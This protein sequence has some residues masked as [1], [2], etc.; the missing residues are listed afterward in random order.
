MIEDSD[1]FAKAQCITQMSDLVTATLAM[2]A[3]LDPTMAYLAAHNNASEHNALK[4]HQQSAAAADDAE[5]EELTEIETAAGDE[6]EPSGRKSP[7]PTLR[8]AIT[9]YS[10]EIEKEQAL[11]RGD[12]GF[13]ESTASHF[14]EW[15]M[16]CAL[17]EVSEALQQ[18]DIQK[19]TIFVWQKEVQHHKM[20]NYY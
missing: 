8:K 3:G 19:A 7:S 1:T 5:E 14:R 10:Q 11:S 2:A 13:I 4:H 15:N 6:T 9:D 12:L 17:E 16:K 20:E 18:R